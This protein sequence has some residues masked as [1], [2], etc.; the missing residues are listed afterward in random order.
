MLFRFVFCCALFMTASVNAATYQCL[1]CPPGTYSVAGAQGASSCIICP[2]GSYCPGGSDKK[3]CPSD[4]SCP[5][6]TVN[7]EDQIAKKPVTCPAGSYVSGDKCP[8]CPAD[9]YCTGG[10]KT[11]P[12]ACPTGQTSPAGSTSSSQCCNLN[13]VPSRDEAHTSPMGLVQGYCHSS[14]GALSS[15][16]NGYTWNGSYG[17]VP[18]GGVYC[19][20]RTK[21]YGTNQCGTASSGAWSSW[22][23]YDYYYD[24]S[25]CASTCASYCAVGVN[26]WGG[27]A[28]W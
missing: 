25:G 10:T 26:N 18:G 17:N 20:C 3:A 13:R 7:L 19:H 9:Y 1:A 8:T 23:Y 16:T 22:V 27:A 28:R 15:G 2:S 5:E 6:G 11:S 24:A 12:T 21:S 4:Y 14:S